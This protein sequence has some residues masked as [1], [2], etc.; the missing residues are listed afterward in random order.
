MIGIDPGRGKHILEETKTIRPREM[1]L[2]KYLQDYVI[3]CW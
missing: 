1:S 3:S 2:Q